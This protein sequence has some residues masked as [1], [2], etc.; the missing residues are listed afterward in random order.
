MGYIRCDGW[1]PEGKLPGRV[2][3]C[4]AAPRPM[5]PLH[6]EHDP[7]AHPRYHPTEKIMQT[8]AE[9]A[10]QSLAHHP[11]PALSLD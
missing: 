11:A 5:G 6:H 2:G 7:G 8:L 3:R 4:N 10:T 9:R 1:E